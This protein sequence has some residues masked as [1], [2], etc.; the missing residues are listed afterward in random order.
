[1][2]IT[3]MLRRI[4]LI[5]AN[6]IKSSESL[7]KQPTQL[8]VRLNSSL[9]H[10]IVTQQLVTPPAGEIYESKMG[11]TDFVEAE[12]EAVEAVEAAAALNVEKNDEGH[13]LCSECK[14]SFTR[15]D[16]LKQVSLSCPA[17]LIL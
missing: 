14:K 8:I 15:L 10:I 13:Y 9:R 7:S 6:K 3:E 5:S 1:M 17:V 4:W 2:G 16:S 12:A 11:V